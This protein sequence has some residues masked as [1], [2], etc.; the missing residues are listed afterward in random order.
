MCRFPFTYKNRLINDSCIVL[1]NREPNYVCPTANEHKDWQKNYDYGYCSTNGCK[2]MKGKDCK[3]YSSL[4]KELPQEKCE[5]EEAQRTCPK[6]CGKC[7]VCECMNGGTCLEDINGD[8]FCVCSGGYVGKICECKTDA[9]LCKLFEK[10]NCDEELRKKCP[11]L[12]GACG[13]E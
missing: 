12:C 8:A 7:K 5:E 3:D 2:F 1:G 4:C 9:A 11:H 10:E 13:G 6:L